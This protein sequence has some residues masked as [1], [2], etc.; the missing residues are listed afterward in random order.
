MGLVRADKLEAGNEKCLVSC[1]ITQNF[2]LNLLSLGLFAFSLLPF[3]IIL[4]NK[5][6]SSKI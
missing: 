6:E 2:S 5:H 3:G 1:V 4:D